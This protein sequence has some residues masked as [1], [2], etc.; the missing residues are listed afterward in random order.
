MQMLLILHCK[1]VIKALIPPG[2][3]APNSPDKAPTAATTS[4]KL[5]PS[6]KPEVEGTTDVPSA[7]GIHP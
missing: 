3:A 4:I 2:T 7:A 1:P 5:L 6:S